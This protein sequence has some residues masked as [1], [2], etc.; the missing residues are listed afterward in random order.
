MTIYDVVNDFYAL[1][2]L[3]NEAMTDPETGEVRELTEEEK[4]DFLAWI[5]EC[6]QN[7]DTKF[8]NIYKAYR[9]IKAEADIAEAER[10]ALKDEIDRLSKRAKARENEASRVKNLFAYA[11]DRLGMKKY[12][13]A[14]FSI[15][16]QAIRKSAKPVDGF[17]NPDNIP[18]EFLKRELS[19]SAINK[20][21]EDGRLYE[22][23]GDI[24]RGKLFYISE[25]G[26]CELKGV[27]YLGG[28]TL[29]IR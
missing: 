6:E 26:E 1:K 21:I 20:A 12:K 19:A 15:G 29:V 16:W 23:E 28:E 24:N 4:T 11:M 9:N 17:F 27:E 18:V 13:T 25:I 8:N 5:E 10:K 2:N 22:K 7:R 14:L 3:T